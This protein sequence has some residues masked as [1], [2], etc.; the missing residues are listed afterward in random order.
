MAYP[1][2]LHRGGV[3]G[4]GRTK[5]TVTDEEMIPEIHRIARQKIKE[6]GFTE[7]EL[8]RFVDKVNEIYRNKIGDAWKELKI[9]E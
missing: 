6:E 9:E 4:S 3:F 7:E 5:N 2:Y 8:K 1:W